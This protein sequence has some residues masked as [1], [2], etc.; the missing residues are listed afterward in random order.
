MEILSW[1]TGSRLGS[2]QILW[3]LRNPKV[4]C[5]GHVSTAQSMYTQPHQSSPQTPSLIF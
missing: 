3:A 5:R 1:E 2:Q 4:Y